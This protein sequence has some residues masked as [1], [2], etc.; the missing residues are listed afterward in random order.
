MSTPA[1]LT[2]LEIASGIV[3]GGTVH[4]LPVLTAGV[5]P[6]DE[7]LVAAIEPAAEEGQLFVSFSGGMD[8]H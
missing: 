8:R 1:P 4:P 6:G 7:A 3:T 5:A 2:P